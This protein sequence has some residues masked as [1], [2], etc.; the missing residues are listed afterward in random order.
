LPSDNL[1]AATTPN[2]LSSNVTW[3]GLEERVQRLLDIVVKL[4]SINAQLMKENQKLKLQSGQAASL[5]PDSHD[6]EMWR[7]KYEEA[8]EDIQHLKDNVQRM[9]QLMN[10][11]GD[12]VR[13]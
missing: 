5:P 6:E 12:V 7:L 8:L 2:I 3:D 1:T 11:K 9:K 13:S 4:R 10:E